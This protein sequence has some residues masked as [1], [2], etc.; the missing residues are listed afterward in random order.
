MGPT[1]TGS[2][3]LLHRLSCPEPA[4][5]ALTFPF[6][7][8]LIPILQ[9]GQAGASPV[10][11]GPCLWPCPEGWPQTQVPGSLGRCGFAPLRSPRKASP[12]MTLGIGHL[13]S[14]GQTVLAPGA[15]QIFTPMVVQTRLAAPPPTF[16]EYMFPDL[17]KLG[18]CGWG[19]GSETMGKDQTKGPRPRWKPGPVGQEK[20]GQLQTV[21]LTRP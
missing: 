15:R 10:A 21:P 1:Q 14:P 16:L 6:W 8:V 5:W 11:Q 2:T 19:R 18:G 17:I 12:Y 20:E 13:P 9:M 3:L 7:A 4:P